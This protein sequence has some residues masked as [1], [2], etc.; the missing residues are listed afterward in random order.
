LLGYSFAFLLRK[1]KLE[2]LAEIPPSSVKPSLI[3]NPQVCLA[4]NFLSCHLMAK[5][6]KIE[7]Q[8]QKRNENGFVIITFFSQLLAELRKKANPK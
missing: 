6:I 7:K 3:N 8:G 2:V 4:R 5:V 1:L